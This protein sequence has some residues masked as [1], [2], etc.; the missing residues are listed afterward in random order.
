MICFRDTFDLDF[1]IQTILL[2]FYCCAEAAM[3]GG[4]CCEGTV[5]LIWESECI[6]D[7][8]FACYYDL[9]F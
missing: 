3:L 1:K 5:A 6:C 7:Y 8:E 9:C 4:Q 2:L